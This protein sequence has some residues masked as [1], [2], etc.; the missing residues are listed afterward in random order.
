MGREREEGR[1]GR[2]SVGGRK[3]VES[4]VKIEG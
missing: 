1:A 4:E 3:G 2:G